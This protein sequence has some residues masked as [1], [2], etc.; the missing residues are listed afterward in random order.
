MHCMCVFGSFFHNNTTSFH[1][2][3][4]KTEHKIA[5]CIAFCALTY[6]SIQMKATLILITHPVTVTLECQPWPRRHIALNPY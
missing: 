1:F 6:F 2:H 4:K 5:L 3:E